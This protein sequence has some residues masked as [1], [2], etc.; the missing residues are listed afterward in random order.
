MGFRVQRLVRGW[1]VGSLLAA[2]AAGAAGAAGVADRVAVPALQAPGSGLDVDSLLARCAPNVAPETAKAAILT[3]SRGHLYAVADAGPVHLPWRERKAMVRSHFLA[4]KASAVR[5]A[6]SLLDRGHTVSLGPGQI[7]DRNLPKLGLTLE[8]VFEPCTN[9]SAM[10]R[11]LSEAYARAVKTF[12]PGQ[13]ALRA[14]LSA[15][16]SGDF[17]RGERDGYVD[18]VFA[19][20][21][22]PLTLRTGTGT[23]TASMMVP[24][25][26]EGGG[27]LV[28]AGPGDRVP[29]ASGSGSGN[30]QSSG[31][32]RSRVSRRETRDFTLAVSAFDSG[33]D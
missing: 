17:Y 30:S 28:A 20:A 33:G 9:F 16:N 6:Q 26:L 27:R 3:E 13:R 21:G 14:A 8:E 4:D 29:G 1:V 18:L 32:S 19:A 25:V 2:L 22:K 12:G 31:L 11:V 15:Y 5:L 7:N 23:G 10:D 24:S